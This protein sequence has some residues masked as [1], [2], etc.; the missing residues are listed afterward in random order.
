[1]VWLFFPLIVGWLHGGERPALLESLS[2]S[3]RFMLRRI[4]RR[5]WRYFDEFVGRASN[6]LPPDNY[7]ESLRVELA[8]RTSPTNI[9]LWLVSSIT[10][11]DFGY[12]TL[13]QL[14]QRHS[15]TLETLRK[16]ESSQ[17]RRLTWHDTRTLEPLH[18]RYVSTVDSGNLL[19]CLW[20]LV[21]S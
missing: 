2:A 16:L 17:G 3:D 4:A 18:P 13:A 20:T 21:E 8:Q 6:W 12:I 11:H 15:S 10:A 7:Q 14:I 19:A 5:T 1:M 9:G